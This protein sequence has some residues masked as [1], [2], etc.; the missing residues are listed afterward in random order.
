MTYKLIFILGLLAQIEPFHSISYKIL[1]YW[2]SLNNN[3]SELP[4]N[5]NKDPG[6]SKWIGILER[7]I[8]Y[9][10][11]WKGAYEATS[12]II[13]G[14]SILRFQS[15]NEHKT[16]E[17]VLVG[18]LLSAALAILTGVAAQWIAAYL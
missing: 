5:F 11:I 2:F 6:I 1:K 15:A 12:F 16:S 10:F 17:Y 8:I 18:T 3:E 7:L 14:K 13:A 4:T 9:T